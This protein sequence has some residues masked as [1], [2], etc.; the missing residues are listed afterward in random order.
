M[1]KVIRTLWK[2]FLLT[3]PFSVHFVLY[4]EASYRFGNFNPWV[5]GFLFLPEIL[6]ILTF[7]L[8]FI[9]KWRNKELGKLKAPGWGLTLFLI[10]LVN[11]GLVTFFQGNLILYLF[12]LVRVL[13]AGAVYVLI[14]QKVLPHSEVIRWLLY[15]AAFQIVLAYLQTRLNHSIGLS[16]IGEP[17]IGPEISNVAKTDLPGGLKEIRP[18]GTFLHPN[19]LGFYLMTILLLSLSYLK[20]AALPF[21]VILLSVGIY[22]TG[23]QAA[24]LTLLIVA[25][26]LL[27]L[28][29]IRVSAQ[30]RILSLGLFFVFLFGNLWVYLNSASLAWSY[31]SIQERLMQNVISLNMLIHHFWGVGVANFTLVMEQFSSV[32]LLPW[33]FQPVHNIYFLVLNETGLQGLLLL[34]LIVAYLL[35]SYWKADLS[36]FLKDKVRILPLFGLIVIASF[37]HLLWTSWIGPILTGMV[38]AETTRNA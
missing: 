27:L 6:L 30:K 33:E 5:T 3:F 29:F 17:V 8:W 13:E 9:Y 32:K 16:F 4:E 23:S 21:W 35:R 26:V 22:L 2:L 10:F 36:Y 18:Y 14:R 1:E 24:Q 38:I 28:S 15:G 31:S 7:L 34:I 11:A 37:D 25:G 12:F 20:K 19:L